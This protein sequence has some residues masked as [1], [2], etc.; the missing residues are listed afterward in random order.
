MGKQK[1]EFLAPIAD[2]SH[3]QPQL[4]ETRPFWP[5]HVTCSHVHTLHPY[6]QFR[7]KYMYVSVSTYV[8]VPKTRGVICPCSW[9]DRWLLTLSVGAGT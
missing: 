9:S 6:T 1:P 3:L 4:Q 8:S 7:K 5:S 2:S